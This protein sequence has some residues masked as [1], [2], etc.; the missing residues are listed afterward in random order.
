MIKARSRACSSL[1]VRREALID[2]VQLSD[3]RRYP[4]AE[5]KAA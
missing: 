5:A 4:V 1:G 2:R 3:L